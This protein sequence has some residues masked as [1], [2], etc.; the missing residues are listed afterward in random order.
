M[1]HLNDP[2]HGWDTGVCTLYI[3]SAADRVNILLTN[4][5]SHR[6]SYRVITVIRVKCTSNV[7]TVV[8]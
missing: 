6:E 1:V 4:L 8:V 7:L 3:G 5:M 2:T